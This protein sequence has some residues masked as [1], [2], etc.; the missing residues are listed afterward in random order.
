MATY[1]TYI[2]AR[3]VPLIMGAYDAAQA[4]EPLSIVLFEGA[5]YTSKQ[6]VPAGVAPT[7]DEYWALTG[8]YNAQVEQ[9]RTEVNEY[10][11]QVTDAVQTVEE[12]LEAQTQA[13]ETKIA[14]Y[15]ENASNKT[16][17][18]NTNYNDKLSSYN[19]NAATKISEYNNNAATK[20]EEFDTAAQQA[21]AAL[22][23]IVRLRKAAQHTPQGA[24]VEFYSL[25]ETYLAQF[26]IT[27]EGEE[28]AVVGISYRINGGIKKNMAYRPVQSQSQLPYILSDQYLQIG[29]SGYSEMSISFEPNPSY[30][31]DYAAIETMDVEV[32][33]ISTGNQVTA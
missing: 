11:Q 4:Y 21:I 33:I 25:I 5:S 27:G 22:P 17:Q 16:E 24:S 20:T 3:Y 9:Y 23:K 30:T 18:F 31:G 8:N 6:A 12:E 32:A 2:G 1:N 7:N 26:G 19:N 28:L 29:Q 14:E 10:K 13:F 15:N